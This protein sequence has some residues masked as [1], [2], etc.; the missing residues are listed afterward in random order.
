[1]LKGRYQRD[2]GDEAVIVEHAKYTDLR[3]GWGQRELIDKD[4]ESDA[5]VLSVPG[6]WSF[7]KSCQWIWL[8]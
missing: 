7:R 6:I 8:W 1:M 5:S 3:G 4:R 2:V